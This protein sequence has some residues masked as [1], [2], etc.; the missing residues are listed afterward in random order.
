MAT[1]TY[2]VCQYKGRSYRLLWKGQTK[3]GLKAK[4]AFMDGSKEFWVDL[5]LVSYAPTSSPSGSSRS[6]GGNRCENCGERRHCCTRPG[7]NCGG[8]DCLS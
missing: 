4:L 5:S 8:Y 7:C 2:E 3:F 6:R 1:G